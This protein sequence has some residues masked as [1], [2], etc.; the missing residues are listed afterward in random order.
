MVVL[1][2]FIKGTSGLE[3]RL[4]RDQIVRDIGAARAEA[5]GKLQKTS[6]Y[7]YTSSYALALS[8]EEPFL[9]TLPKDFSLAWSPPETTG[10]ENEGVETE[11]AEET[12]ETEETVEELPEPE[13]EE[14]E[15]EEGADR[16]SGTLDFDANGQ[17]AGGRLALTTPSGR[18][19]TLSVGEDGKLVWI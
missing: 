16:W 14:P 9:R 10:E 7:F 18:T 3:A 4:W 5:I 6:V 11:S 15:E 1:P 13:E 19:F 8:D 12:E 17:C 2:A